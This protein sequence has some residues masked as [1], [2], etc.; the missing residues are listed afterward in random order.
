MAA[1]THLRALRR[2]L[3]LLR[4]HGVM[5]YQD[6]VHRIVLGAVEAAPV[7]AARAARLE[8]SPEDAEDRRL[9]EM[10]SQLGFSS[11]LPRRS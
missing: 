2:L 10:A 1:A 4:E 6:G 5:E 3:A 9:R 11:Q 8:E 7:A